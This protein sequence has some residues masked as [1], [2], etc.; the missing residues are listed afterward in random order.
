VQAIGYT[1][2][3][4]GDQQYG[5]GAQK[6]AIR[7]AA[8]ARGW[9]VEWVEEPARSGKN[10]DRPKLQAALAELAAGH[11]DVLVVSRL[12]RLSRSLL[13]F[14]SLVRR[15]Q[16]EGWALVVLNPALDL[17]T[18]EGRLVANI[19]VSLAEFERELIGARIREGLAEAKRRGKRLGR[20]QRVSP[21][22]ARRIIREREL[23]ASLHE[24]A[25]GLNKDGVPTARGG[26][27]WY[28]ATIR[29][30]LTA[31]AESAG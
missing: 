31:H 4:T 29:G 12:D 3:S 23:G 21:E 28:A 25:R 20:T 15:S 22:V 30:V 16:Q 10:L 9:Q 26:H 8:D 18:S 7:Q 14:T 5:I 2:V 27:E 17:S 11:A 13:D 19:L 1:R 6:D 24:I